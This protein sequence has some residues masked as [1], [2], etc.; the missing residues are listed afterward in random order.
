VRFREDS[1]VTPKGAWPFCGGG[2]GLG[3]GAAGDGS[4]Q[5]HRERTDA[6]QYRAELPDDFK[7]VVIDKN[8]ARWKTAIADAAKAKLTHGQ[9]KTY[10]TREAKRVMDA[11][12]EKSRTAAPA[13]P[14]AA[15]AAPAK[16]AKAHKDMS[17]SEQLV[18][19]GHAKV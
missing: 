1:T 17:F 6:D 7:S 9:F 3:G 12:V 5:S 2:D 19:G 16:P 8:D 15:A 11:H 14:A 13:T 10:L 4:A 18:A